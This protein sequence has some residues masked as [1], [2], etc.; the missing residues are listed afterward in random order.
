[1]DSFTHFFLKL[2]HLWLG[3]TVA[4]V[5]TLVMI[6]VLKRI[7]PN[8]GLVD[9][10]GMHRGH[11]RTTPLIGGIAMFVGIMFGA[12]SLDVPLAGMRAFF[13][14][15]AVVLIVGMLDDMK[16][17]PTIV[18]FAAQIAA[19]LMMALWGGVTLENLGSLVF[20]NHTA[21]LGFWAVP[22]T[23][24]A[25]V[26]LINAFNM[27]DGTDGQG[28][29]L[30]MVALV[31]VMLSVFISKRTDILPLVAMTTASVGIFLCFNLRGPWRRQASVFMGD[32]GSMLL[33][34]IVC[35]YL[36]S[37]SHSQSPNGTGLAIRPVTALW[38]VAL[39]L[40]DT[41][42]VMMRRIL[43]GGSPFKAD[44]T[45]YHH[46]LRAADLGINETIAVITVT[47]INF[48]GFGLVGEAYG[49]S[50]PVMFYTFLFVFLIWFCGTYFAISAFREAD[51]DFIAMRDRR[52]SDRDGIPASGDRRGGGPDRRKVQRYVKEEVAAE[53][54]DG[55]M[56]PMPDKP[57]GS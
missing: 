40:M 56:G 31:G 49:V 34:F 13:A 14:G 38:L 53:E 8:I 22:L 9:A 6:F 45:H 17:L 35:W 15:C 54:A 3:V 4:A 5:V 33:G 2:N 37:L 25:C 42:T 21:L 1:M 19:G 51:N 23:V 46:L 12:L 39:P 44:R 55:A 30:V 26:G 32:A 7:A 50:E 11:S 10:P 48:A 57:A 29:I 41:I 27:S 16:E 36:V 20:H 52:A 28:G 43:E 24:F 18:R 47:A